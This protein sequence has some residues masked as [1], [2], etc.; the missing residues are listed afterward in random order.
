ML[1]EIWLSNAP[2]VNAN[3][4]YNTSIQHVLKKNLR[5]RNRSIKIVTATKMFTLLDK[6]SQEKNQAAPAIYKALIFSLV[7]S[8]HDQTAREMFLTNFQFLFEQNRAIP[9]GLL[10]DP[11]IKSNQTQD[12]FLFQTFDYDFF[13]FIA[14]H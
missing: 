8:P 5:D 6:F 2:F 4:Q 10:M 3:E 12:T 11:F 14:G 7:E 1:T 9:V 13:S